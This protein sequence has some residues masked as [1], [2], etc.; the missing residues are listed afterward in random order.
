MTKVARQEDS[1]SIGVIGK[2]DPRIFQPAWLRSENLL[3]ELEAKAATESIDLIVNANITSWQT[4]VMLVQVTPDRL[5][6]LGKGESSAQPIRDFVVGALSLVPG[7]EAKLLGLNRSMHF[8][9]GSEENWHRV[10]DAL[11]PKSFWSGPLGENLGMLNLQIQQ[12]PRQDGKAG[13]AVVTVQ[14]SAK[15]PK[16][17]VFIEVNNE[18]SDNEQFADLLASHWLRI[19][20]EAGKLA[21][22]LLTGV[23]T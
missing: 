6:V 21:E 19:Q 7:N 12:A 10:G 20:E 8:S 9:V 17:G 1:P 11:A 5:F 4:D 22:D 2:F 18:F 14:P 13:R 15:L 3:G 23:L 16:Q